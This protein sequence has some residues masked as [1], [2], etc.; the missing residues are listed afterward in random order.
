MIK[1]S[2]KRT[3]WVN[4]D[5]LEADDLSDSFF[6]NKWYDV[7]RTDASI[8]GEMRGLAGHSSGKL[9]VIVGDGD[10]WNT[11]DSGVTWTEKNTT[12]S[13]SPFYIK[14]CKADRTYAI[15]VEDGASADT[16]YTADSGATWTDGGDLSA[17]V[18][19]VNDLSVPTTTLAVVAVADSNG[20]TIQRSTDNGA[21]WVDATTSPGA[22]VYCVDMIDGTTGFAVALGG[23]IWKTTDSGDTWVDTTHIVTSPLVS[24]TM[25]A[26]SSTAVIFTAVSNSMLAFYD[27]TQNAYNKVRLPSSGVP[28]NFIKLANGYFYVVGYGGVTNN[29]TILKSTDSGVNW[30]MATIPASVSMAADKNKCTLSEDAD[31]TLLVNLST[32]SDGNILKIYEDD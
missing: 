10:I 11:A 12:L 3:S 25:Y 2:D 30:K 4:G 13:S 17:Q 15:A 22:E 16:S 20:D 32:V 19:A 23:G 26:I 9:S 1:I 27:G 5:V 21:N 24:S 28:S 6:A 7:Y 8:V 31:N 29:P 14:K 18:T